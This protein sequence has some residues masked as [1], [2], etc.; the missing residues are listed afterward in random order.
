MNRRYF[1]LTLLYGVTAC[2]DQTLTEPAVPGPNFEIADAA[3]A[4]KA[5]FYWL[6]PTV[7]DPLYAGTFDAVLSPA[8]EICELVD[9]ACGT[10]IATYTMTTGPGGELVRLH[11]DEENYH[12]NWHTDE[13]ELSTTGFY[14]VSVRAGIYDVLLGFADVQ[15]VSNGSGLKNVDTGEYIGLVDGRTLPIKF[16]IETGIV[17]NVE[18]QPIE[19]TVEP[20]ATQQ[21]IATR[22]DLRGN[23][24]SG[25][26][27]WASS[28]EAV[29]TV[30]ETGLATALADGVAIITATSERLAGSAT[31]TVVDFG[32]CS[33]FQPIAW[34]SLDNRG[35]DASGNGND[36]IVQGA[37]PAADRHGTGS[38]ALSF[39]GIDDAIEL[40]DRFNTLALPF[41]I[42]A[43]IHQPASAR[44]EFRSIFI[45]DD[46][47][48]RYAGIW[49]QLDPSGLPQ[50]T[51]A[52]GGPVGPG[53][54]RTLSGN[55]P[56][57]TDSWVHIAATVRGSTDMTL[58][59][60]GVAVPGTYSGSGGALLHTSAPARVGV[61]STNPAN[62]PWLGLLDEIQIYD[63]SL[64]ARGIA[65]LFA[66]R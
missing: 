54:R 17:G 57:P 53:F 26:L 18:V 34:Y 19:A 44:G 22:F 55:D 48:A 21:F 24:M 23:P 6:P 16:R 64:E 51:F 33:P 3:R 5:G 38:S 45:T 47:P 63:C 41:T 28:D 66:Q 39:D 42:D 27:S 2:A 37:S 62:L 43:W 60:N 14:R 1:L 31:L 36:G 65:A 11:V 59:V 58:Y 46:Q 61:F 40:G 10:V 7:A 12:V 25:A 15:P 13:F 4:Y 8:V 56:V 20:E 50:I 49:F 9:G 29:A 35:D 32:S 52:D 30:D